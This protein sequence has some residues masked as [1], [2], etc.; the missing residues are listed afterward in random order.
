MKQS[1]AD[2][3]HY[4]SLLIERP[5]RDSALQRH[6][7]ARTG[8]FWLRERKGGGAKEGGQILSPS[9]LSHLACDPR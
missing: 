4:R 7:L 5:K 8:Q 1:V 2:R 6:T 9:D 3:G